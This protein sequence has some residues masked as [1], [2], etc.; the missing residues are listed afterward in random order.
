MK[1]AADALQFL[2]TIEDT[3][4]DPNYVRFSTNNHIYILTFFVVVHL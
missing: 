3:T 1:I 4:A 2:L